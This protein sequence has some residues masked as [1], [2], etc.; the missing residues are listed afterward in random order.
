MHTVFVHFLVLILVF[1]GRYFVMVSVM[2]IFAVLLKLDGH[3][4]VTELL[5]LNTNSLV[6]NF[7]FLI[8]QLHNG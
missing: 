1:F 3:R 8:L 2:K 6:K 7:G 5:T 4:E